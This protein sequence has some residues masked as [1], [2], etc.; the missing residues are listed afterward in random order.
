MD[1]KKCPFKRE[2]HELP[3][4]LSCDDVKAIM[5]VEPPEEET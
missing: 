1:C 4:D 5:A 2:C 3:K